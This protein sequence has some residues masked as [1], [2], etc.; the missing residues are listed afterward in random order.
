MASSAYN[1]AIAIEKAFKTATE[2]IAQARSYIVALEG[3][4]KLILKTDDIE[5]VYASGKH[6]LILDFQGTL[7]FGNDFLK[8][9]Y[10]YKLGLRIVQ[11]TCNLQN[12][13]VTAALKGIKRV[14]L[15]LTKRSS[16]NLT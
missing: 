11:I 7:P 5:E 8:I 16:K 9:K 3:E 14:S 12:W 10:F 15:I 1:F 6:G 13:L 2:G 4:L